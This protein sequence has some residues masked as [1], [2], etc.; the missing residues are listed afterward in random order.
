MNLIEQRICAWSVVVFLVLLGIG[1]VVM[2]RFLP[3]HLPGASAM[4]IAAIYQQNTVWIRAGLALA[5]L[6]SAFIVP[7]I[8]LIS[9]QM[10]RIQGAGSLLANTQMI[11]G[12]V[13]VMMI[14]TVPFMA[15]E[16]IAFRPDRP[17]EIILAISDFAW[18]MFAMTLSPALVQF[19]SLGIAILLD[20]SPEPVFPRWAGFL[21]IWISVL[22]LPAGAIALFH[23]GPFAWNGVLAFWLPVVLFVIWILVMFFLLLKMIRQQ[24]PLAR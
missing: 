21:N 12:S 3:P 1:W 20:R 10:R 24:E 23:S 19:L 9:A 13:G 17:V 2:A 4:E 8:V 7:F 18:L 5:M 15:W 6:G 14:F 16:T 22:A 11:C